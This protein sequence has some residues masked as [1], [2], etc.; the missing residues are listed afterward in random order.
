MSTIYKCKHVIWVA[1]DT[2]NHL[3]YKKQLCTQDEFYL[4]FAKGHMHLITLD[5]FRASEPSV[6]YQTTLAHETYTHLN[7]IAQAG[8]LPFCHSAT[9]YEYPDQ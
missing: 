8:K 6:Q 1:M 5:S 7:Y 4:I 3:Q 2:Q 9:G